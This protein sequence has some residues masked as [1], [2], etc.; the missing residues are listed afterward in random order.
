MSKILIISPQV[1][2]PLEDGGKKCMYYQIKAIAGVATNEITLVMGNND[3]ENIECLNRQYLP[4]LS[5]VIVYNRVSARIKK[6][7]LWLKIGETI[8]WL[9]S[10]K[11]RPAQTISNEKHREEITSYILEHKIEQVILETPYAAEYIDFSRLK[12]KM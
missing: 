9:L 2:L 6:S 1:I 3:L 11:P 5:R 12:G 4:F 7:G 8:K 10:G